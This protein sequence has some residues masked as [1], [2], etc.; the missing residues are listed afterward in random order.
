[1][2]YAYVNNNPVR[3]I[4]PDGMDGVPSDLWDKGVLPF[5]QGVQGEQLWLSEAKPFWAQARA[6]AKKRGFTEDLYQY[7]RD[8]KALWGG[9]ETYA[10]GYQGKP[11][12]FL[13]PGED[14]WIA[15]QSVASNAKQSQME[16]AL[17]GQAREWGIPV[18]EADLFPGAQLGKRWGQ[19]DIPTI[20]GIRP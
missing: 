16:K 17:A 3:L 8:V 1:N 12:A 13:E 11:F 6:T 9:P 20:E 15:I 19:P 4:D 10:L 18:R 2:R 14:S 5:W 7:F